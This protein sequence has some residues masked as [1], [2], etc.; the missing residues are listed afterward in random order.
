MDRQHR[1]LHFVMLLIV[2]SAG[3]LALMLMRTSY[4]TGP[5]TLEPSEQ[6]IVRQERPGE[7]VAQQTSGRRSV[8]N[9]V[10]VHTFNDADVIDMN[11]APNLEEGTIVTA[12]TPVMELLS[13][14]DQAMEKMLV[15]RVRRLTEQVAQ[16]RTG[17]GLAK[18][19][20]AQA[21]L[22][23]G[24]RREG[25]FGAVASVVMKSATALAITISGFVLYMTGFHKELG[26]AQTAQTLLLM[27]IMFSFAPLVLLV[28]VQ[29]LLLKYPLTARRMGEIHVEL[30]HRR[31]AAAAAAALP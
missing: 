1:L 18:V 26:G 19:E 5:F 20:E 31:A 16:L 3:I 10:S 17:E 22:L 28:L 9:A 4:L 29:V 2:V 6:W 12:G 13:L 21:K 27:R 7:I 25:M 14:T 15:A 11:L 8:I 30:K 24:Q 23:S